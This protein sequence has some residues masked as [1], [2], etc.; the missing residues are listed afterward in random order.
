MP[1]IFGG[2]D[3]HDA[4]GQ[5]AGYTVESVISGEY[6]YDTWT[7]IA[8]L[9]SIAVPSFFN[10]WFNDFCITAPYNAGSKR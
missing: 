2:Q 4:N 6:F 10:F 3:F 5:P 1:G 9:A 7:G 8:I